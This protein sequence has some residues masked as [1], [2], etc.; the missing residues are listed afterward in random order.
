MKKIIAVLAVILMF[1]VVLTACGKK[2]EDKATDD[3]ATNDSASSS[4]SGAAKSATELPSATTVVTETTAK[5]NTFEKDQA[6]NIIEIDPDGEIV[7]IKDPDGKSLDI[8]EYLET[9]YFVSSSGKVYGDPSFMGADARKDSKQSD[10]SSQSGGEGK[11]SG[12]SSKGQSGSSSQEEV[13]KEKES[14]TV[15]AELPKQTDEYELPI[16]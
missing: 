1:T 2:D 9:H 4:A 7:S 15:V 3:T 12:S 11:G 13:I 6:G 5:G 16:L 8:P 14:P 10:S